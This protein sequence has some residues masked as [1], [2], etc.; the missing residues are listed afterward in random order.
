M[1]EGVDICGR[2]KEIKTIYEFIRQRADNKESG[3][4][5]LTGPPGTGKTM[6]VDWVLHKL[7]DI[8]RI[9]INCLRIASSRDILKKL[10]LSLDLEKYSGNNESEMI[11]R[12]CKKMSSRSAKTQILVLDELDQLPQSKSANLIKSIFDWPSQPNSRLILIGIANAV[13]L[14]SRYQVVSALTGRERC[15]TKII[16]RPY[17]SSDIRAILEWYLANDENYEEDLVEPKALEMIAKKF[18]R[19]NGDIRGALNAL[20]SS[21]EDCKRDQHRVEFNESQYPT[22]PSTPTISPCKEKTN[23]ASVA[24]S[25]KKRQKRTNYKEDMT[26]YAHQVLLASVMKLCSKND[27][28]MVSVRACKDLAKKALKQFDF[29]VPDMDYISM[30]E[31]LELQGF[32]SV[33]KGRPNC[34]IVLRASEAEIMPLIQRQEQV[35]G[36]ISNLI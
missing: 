7:Q 17:N 5:Y 9:K 4:L 29:S 18:A 26:P 10:C 1:D 13:N 25:C 28:N 22:P 36:I 30:F 19:E 35:L 2:E 8:P 3:T 24:N 11:A 34:N 32:I 12:I 23:I 33:K 27:N 21:I 20:K 31:T 15:F 16:F 14:T 6:S